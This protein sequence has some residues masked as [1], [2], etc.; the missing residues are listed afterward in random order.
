MDSAASAAAGSAALL[1]STTFARSA[2]AESAGADGAGAECFHCGVPIEAGARHA[3]DIGGRARPMCCAGCQAVAAAIV[4]AGL[5]SY[6]QHRTA[7]PNT[8]REALPELVRELAVYDHPDVQRTFV[9]AEGESVREAWL[10]L[11][12]ITCAACMWLNE[13]RLA[14]LPGVVSVE[15]NYAT[16]RLRVRWDPSRARLS[17][18]LRAVRELGYA[19]HPFDPLRQQQILEA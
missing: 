19:A 1:G 16:H 17:G 11:E 10:L 5:E 13:H 3:V 7:R 12:G 6:Y 18:I 4:A 9:R 15:A 2:G 8:A 14:A